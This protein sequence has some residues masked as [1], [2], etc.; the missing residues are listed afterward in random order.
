MF[1][2][3]Q[4][5]FKKD[6]PRPERAAVLLFDRFSNHCLANLVEPMRAVNT[7]T[8][9]R[10]YDWTC[11][12]LDGQSVVSSSGLPILPH[13]RLA[14]IQ[15]GDY[16]FVMPSYDVQALATPACLN[17]LRAASRR[18]RV[19]AGLDTGSWL[20]AAADLLTGRQATI[21]WDAIEGFAET[22]PEVDVV[23]RK[24]VIDGARITCGGAMTAFDL[25]ARLIGQRFGEAMR[26]EVAAFFLIGSAGH[27]DAP[28]AARPR[29]RLVET[30]VGLM[31]SH[32]E[33]PLP[34]PD[35]ARQAGCR[36]RELENRFRREL[37][38]TPRTVYRRLR[39]GAARRYAESSAYPVAEI[40]LRC[41]YRDAGAMTR[42]FRLEFG[43]TP[44]ELRR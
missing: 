25:I 6:S 32:V 33:N 42:A 34:I 18:F 27:D 10:A 20:M 43:V 2:I 37:A 3:M 11:L 8:G 29:S 24:Y 7:L 28:P 36:P 14:D 22:F 31:Q 19:I 5:S 4:F 40:A 21:H 12:T 1:E 9:R 17:A 13:G 16:L 39:L 26:L 30:A 35:I 23:R 41:G 44:R 38:A 15:T